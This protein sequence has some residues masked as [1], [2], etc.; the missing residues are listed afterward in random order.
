[1]TVSPGKTFV[2]NVV[3]PTYRRPEFLYWTL[4]TVLKQ[5]LGGG[6]LRVHVINN[7]ADTD[8]VEDAV[9]RAIEA[10]PA[11]GSPR[12]V[13][14]VHRIP[15]MPPA[16]S[17]SAAMRDCAADGE[18]LVVHCDDDL[19]M[20]GSLRGRVESLLS[21][22]PGAC[23][24]LSRD[25]G[26]LFYDRERSTFH[27]TPHL[28]QSCAAAIAGPARRARIGDLARYPGGLFSTYTYLINDCYR[29]VKAAYDDV[30][31]RL[32]PRF[33]EGAAI[34]VPIDLGTAAAV[35]G[36]L[37]VQDSAVCARGMYVHEYT[38][39]DGRVAWD[40]GYL[41]LSTMAFFDNLAD[42]EPALARGALAPLRQAYRRQA[43]RWALRFLA[44]GGVR[45]RLGLIW[46]AD[47]GL[48]RALPSLIGGTKTLVG[49]VMA[50]HRLLRLVR[51]IP[52]PA[53]TGDEMFAR[54]GFLAS[55]SRD[56]Q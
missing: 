26:M 48:V 37:L 39:E 21:A 7:D 24:L 5:E 47:P 33:R 22:G 8:P 19:M 52:S 29:S 2:V 49:G 46:S 6:L 27:F 41:Y 9:R 15:P 35:H 31:K 36:A 10:E 54:L 16:E 3:I 45:A 25:A 28:Q 18:L 20:P 4:R 55:H 42:R 1:M 51:R 34:M 56:G 11:I 23:A 12:D 14:I 32:D 38:A 43:A 53:L 44:T 40:A 30:L 13:R 50:K 17:W